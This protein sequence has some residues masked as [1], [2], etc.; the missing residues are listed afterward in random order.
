MAEL[1]AAP[2]H[3]SPPAREAH[4]QVPAPQQQHVVPQVQRRDLR[5]LSAHGHEDGI[6]ELDEFIF[7][8]H[9]EEKGEPPPLRIGRR[10]Q[11]GAPQRAAVRPRERRHL[12]AQLEHDVAVQQHLVDIVREH[13]GFDAGGR[14][15]G[16]GRVRAA[17]RAAVATRIEHKGEVGQRHAGRHS[18]RLE[19]RELAPV[20]GGVVQPR[21]Q[22][23]VHGDQQQWLGELQRR[24]RRRLAAGGGGGGG[25]GGKRGGG[26]S[27]GGGGGGGGRGALRVARAAPEAGDLVRDVGA[28]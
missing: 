3:A 6:G 23:E 10:E 9:K 4:D 26:G 24:L 25:G 22:R 18:R 20:D 13:P 21:E 27:G 2:N 5:A 12:A 17:G 19:Q 16:L 11:P 15:R 1:T 8:V 7:G 14:R 28:A